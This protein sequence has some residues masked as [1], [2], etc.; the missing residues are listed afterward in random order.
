MDFASKI[1]CSL[2]VIILLVSRIFIIKLRWE[3][4]TN[5]KTTYWEDKYK[6]ILNNYTYLYGEYDSASINYLK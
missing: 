6:S 2:L 5:I 3:T 4:A 1:K